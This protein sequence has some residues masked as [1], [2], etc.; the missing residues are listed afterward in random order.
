VIFA[1]RPAYVDLLHGAQAGWSFRPGDVESL[2]DALTEAADHAEAAMRGQNALAVARSLDWHD[3]AQ[4]TV[5]ALTASA[6]HGT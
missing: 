1:E 6:A 4:Q 5:A 2:R 3:I